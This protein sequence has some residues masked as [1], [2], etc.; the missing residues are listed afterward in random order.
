MKPSYW[1][2]PLLLAGAGCHSGNLTPLERRLLAQCP[3]K[4]ADCEVRLAAATDFAWTQCFIFEPDKGDDY[5]SQQLGQ[6]FTGAEEFSQTIVFLN[7]S[8]VVYRENIPVPIEH[9]EDGDMAL[10]EIEGVY[11][12]KEA[13][14]HLR[15][16]D[17]TAEE[18]G[19]FLVLTRH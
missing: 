7:D 14:F 1:L 10:F 8:A 5:I 12:P 4:R 3:D 15:P 19:R 18:A 17:G 6:P 2:L 11:T 13:V 9:V 16:S